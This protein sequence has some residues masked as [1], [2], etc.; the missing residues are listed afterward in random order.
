V[1][2]TDYRISDTDSRRW[3]EEKVESVWEKIR[4]GKQIKE[5]IYVD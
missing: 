4:S 2:L 5:L 3:I 1:S